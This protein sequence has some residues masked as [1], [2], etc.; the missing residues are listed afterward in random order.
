MPDRIDV[1]VVEQGTQRGIAGVAV[2]T[3]DG[4]A[5][6][7][8]D[9]T[10]AIEVDPLARFAWIS[11]PE[12]KRP[13]DDFYRPLPVS[14]VVFELAAAPASAGNAAR[15][16]QFS[17]THLVGAGAPVAAPDL[18]NALDALL[19][20]SAPDLLIASGD[21]T[22]LGTPAELAELQSATSA[23]DTPLF[24]MFGGHDG[25]AER[26]SA[27][28][29]PPFTLN[30]E[31]CFGPTYYSFD[32][33]GRHIALWPNEETFF[34]SADRERK[35]RWLDAD[36]SL[37]A[38][39]GNTILVIHT[40]P[41][42]AFIDEM[43]GLGVSLILHG[44]WHSM[45]SFHSNGVTVAATG[46]L[47][48]GGIDTTPR[49]Y[50]VVEWQGSIA[51]P[52]RA[53]ALGAKRL[54]PANPERLGPFRLTWAQDVADDAEQPLVPAHRA[55]PALSGERL[56]LGGSCNDAGA[57]Q[58]RSATTGH[59]LWTADLEAAVRNQVTPAGARVLAL[60]MTGALYSLRLEDGSVEWRA[61]LPGHPGRWL[62]TMPV[63]ADGIVYAGGK[64]G[65][66]AYRV[67][68][69]ECDWYAEI[70]ASDAWSCY[71]SPLITPEVIVL[72]VSRRGLVALSRTDG[73]IAWETELDV[74]YQYAAPVRWGDDILTGSE[75]RRLAR[76]RLGDGAIIWHGESLA[77]RYPC[78]LSVD[79]ERI[80]VSTS[81]G[82]IQALDPETG[83][84]QWRV[85]TG[86]DLLDMTPYARGV[87]SSLASPVRMGHWLIV[88]ACDGVLRLL[89]PASGEVHAAAALGAPITAPIQPIDETALLLSTWDGRLL[90]Y[91]G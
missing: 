84:E 2:T 18:A 76:L 8:A 31:A 80:Y 4:I 75:A 6:T 52:T 90:R 11:C 71:A 23:V 14:E 56:L 32:W 26:R 58:C 47:C 35:R 73:R 70:E 66:G 62:Y 33:A 87:R 68:S 86:H 42:R 44:H 13:V 55:A 1:I 20:E 74:E 21:L 89:D 81:A 27:G 83:R 63:C 34:S 48:F 88:G 29:E 91:D 59:L 50:R 54:Q 78:A 65:I 22:N 77:G 30:W 57:V 5:T 24:L 61:N 64:A 7:G 67:D 3:G 12:G 53:V 46:P 38:D 79:N 72:L 16:V 82:A 40:P 10:C 45:K 85:D 37:N 69:G 25:N 15:L 60:A 51:P 9:G 28:N 36:L 19:S 39:R 49:G 41:S 43:T 17:D